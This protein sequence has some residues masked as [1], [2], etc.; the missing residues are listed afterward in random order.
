MN[1]FITLLCALVGLL[2]ATTLESW[3]RSHTA[4]NESSSETQKT[5]KS[6]NREFWTIQLLP[7]AIIMIAVGALIWYGVGTKNVVVFAAG[8]FVSFISV[9]SASNVS[10]SG[11]LAASSH[12]LNGNIRDALRSSYRSASVMSLASSSIALIGLGILFFFLNTNQLIMYISSFALGASIVSMCLGLSGSTFSGAYSLT[13]KSDDYTDYTG[14]FAGSAADFIETYI[15]ASSAA[16]LL[17]GVG[18]DSSGLSA[19]FT[20]TSAARYPL[21]IYAAGIVA[22][23]IGILAYRGK[24]F[25]DPE[26]G[27]TIGN[28]IAG[29]IIIAVA[30]YFSMNVLESYIYGIC[31][32]SGIISALLSGELS[33]PFSSYGIIFKKRVPDAKL[34]G[35]SQSMIYSLSIGMISLFIPTALTVAS[36]IVSYNYASYYGIALAACGICSMSAVDMAVRGF[37]INSASASEIASVLDPDAESPSS[38]DV[39]LTASVRSEVVGKTY[40]A[41]STGVTLV[42]LFTAIS[43]VTENHSPELLTTQVFAGI[44]IAAVAVFVVAGLIIRSIRLTSIVLRERIDNPTDD[45]RTISNLRGVLIVYLLAVAVPILTGFAGSI[46]GLIAFA[47]SASITGMCVLFTFNNS[48]KY[49]DRMATETLGTIIKVMVVA[50]L[51]SAPFFMNLAAAY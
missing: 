17:A 15:L 24:I 29:I 7:L 31:V 4:K 39:L 34:V 36:L 49:F 30:F 23:V 48:G 12:A 1:K 10:V 28:I 46:N 32:G 22:S 13:V 19:T 41:V 38:A 18:V 14:V 40:S 20:A 35:A 8:A 51:V 42:A 50:T 44:T 21:I 26:S 45:D 27:L 25:K 37:S 3:I 2:V 6:R 43:V 16:A 33:K 47:C 11:S 9:F 5:L